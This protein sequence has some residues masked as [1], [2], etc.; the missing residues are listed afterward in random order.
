MMESGVFQMKDRLCEKDDEQKR[1]A[2][3]VIDI[4]PPFLKQKKVDAQLRTSVNILREP[5]G[6]MALACKK[7][8]ALLRGLRERN[9]RIRSQGGVFDIQGS[10]LQ[11]VLKLDV[12]GDKQGDTVNDA[13]GEDAID[14]RQGVD[15]D[16]HKARTQGKYADHMK[17]KYLDEGSDFVRGKTIKQQREYLPIY[18]VRDELVRLVRDNKIVII[19][20]ETGSGKTT[21]LA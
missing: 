9:E 3:K 7:G 8:S 11:R 1:V 6:D 15:P 14:H 19:V 17:R 13:V 21:Q 5:L 12:I 18:S 16:A 4:K 2:L 10:Q 20:G